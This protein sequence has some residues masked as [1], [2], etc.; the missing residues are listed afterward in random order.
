MSRK[1]EITEKKVKKRYFFIEK[2]W[3]H[4]TVDEKRAWLQESKKTTLKVAKPLDLSL[5]M[6]SF[7]LADSYLN[8]ASKKTSCFDFVRLTL[9]FLSLSWVGVINQKKTIN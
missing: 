5:I 4:A 1:K 7:I 9:H 2:V 8:G 6:S 3:R